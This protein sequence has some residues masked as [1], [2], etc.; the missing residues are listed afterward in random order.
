MVVLV[1]GCWDMLLISWL[2]LLRWR[3]VF[4]KDFGLFH[5]FKLFDSVLQQPIPKPQ[6][7]YGVLK[8]NNCSLSCVNFNPGIL[9]IQVLR[10]GL[11][12]VLLDRLTAGCCA[13]GTTWSL[14]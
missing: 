14:E 8:D 6:V 3:E 10:R 9:K 12:F 13:R 2:I 7:I 4:F 1:V 11:I 5:P